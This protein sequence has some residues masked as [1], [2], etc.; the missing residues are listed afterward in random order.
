MDKKALVSVIIVAVLVL[1]LTQ[2]DLAP[3]LR[4][5]INLAIAAVFAI[6]AYFSIGKNSTIFLIIFAALAGLY[7]RAAI[8]IFSGM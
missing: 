5:S 7:I 8:I 2:L 3:V 1:I 6:N 4:G